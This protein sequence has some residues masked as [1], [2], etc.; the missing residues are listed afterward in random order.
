VEPIDFYTTEL[1]SLLSVLANYANHSANVHEVLRCNAEGTV[2]LH[3][4]QSEI[5]R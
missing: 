5:S 2:L 1:C 3:A 4:V